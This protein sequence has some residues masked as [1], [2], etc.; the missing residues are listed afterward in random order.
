MYSC[1]YLLERQSYTERK[2][3]GKI[4]SMTPQMAST[5]GARSF[6]S[7]ELPLDLPYG[8]MHSRTWAIFRCLSF[9][10]W[11]VSKQPGLKPTLMF[12][13]NTTGGFIH[14]TTE[15]TPVLLSHLSLHTVALACTRLTS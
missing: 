8:S 12:N 14:C 6:P 11:I 13:G 5:G 1:I 4:C 10:C 3:E 7:R 2:L 15:K 9:Y